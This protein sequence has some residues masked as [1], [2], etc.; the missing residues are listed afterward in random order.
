M[1]KL[2][3]LNSLYQSHTVIGKLRFADVFDT[4][5][6]IYISKTNVIVIIRSVEVN[7]ISTDTDEILIEGCKGL[8]ED[9]CLTPLHHKLITK[10]FNFADFKKFVEKQVVNAR[11]GLPDLESNGYIGRIYRLKNSKVK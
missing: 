10:T 5:N 2:K 3:R 8:L 6:I 1:L 9:G 7:H 4:P 11:V